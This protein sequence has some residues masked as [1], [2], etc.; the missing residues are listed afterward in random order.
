MTN[1]YKVSNNKLIIADKKLFQEYVNKNHGITPNI[2]NNIKKIPSN[3]FKGIKNIKY[4]FLPTNIKKIDI[5]VL[6]KMYGIVIN[7]GNYYEFTTRMLTPEGKKQVCLKVERVA[8]TKKFDNYL[9]YHD[10]IAPEIPEGVS[11]LGQF[12]F[13]NNKY[14]KSIVLPKSLTA[15]H[16]QSFMNSSL[17]TITISPKTIYFGEEAF[18]NCV[19]LDYMEI[20]KS[21]RYIKPNVFTKCKDSMKINIFNKYLILKSDFVL[22]GNLKDLYQLE[23]DNPNSKIKSIRTKYGFYI[24]E[25]DRTYF[26]NKNKYDFNQNIDKF[27]GYKYEDNDELFVSNI[28]YKAF[29]F[30]QKSKKI[31]DG[32]K[33]IPYTFIVKSTDIDNIEDYYKNEEFLKKNILNKICTISNNRTY[34]KNN[35]K[36]GRLTS[37]QYETIYKIAIIS[38]LFETNKSK[39]VNLFTQILFGIYRNG[40]NLS[41]EEFENLFSD[42]AN[43]CSVKYNEEFSEYFLYNKNN[44]IKIIKAA[45][46]KKNFLSDLYNNSGES[47]IYY[48]HDGK[49][50]KSHGKLHDMWIIYKNNNKRKKTLSFIDWA[51]LYGNESEVINNLNIEDKYKNILKKFNKYYSHEESYNKLYNLFRLSERV[52]PYA[53]Y[54]CH[55]S[56][57]LTVNV[58]PAEFQVVNRTFKINEKYIFDEENYKF[59]TVI[60]KNYCGEI[61][62]K[63]SYKVALFNCKL[64]S[65]AN[66]NST[67]AEYLYE[68]YLDPDCQP[69]VIF[70]KESNNPVATFRI[71]I[72]KNINIASIVSFEVSEIFKF[73]SNV[74]EKMNVVKIFEELVHNFVYLY[75][76]NNNIKIN[77]IVMGQVPHCGI[78]E[79]FNQKYEEI[80]V[81]YDLNYKRV[82]VNPS[83]KNNYLIWKR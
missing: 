14:L 10:G 46:N 33:I 26:F 2:P 25:N 44:L 41:I 72:Y 31:I 9:K 73:N 75:E 23:C 21:V 38:G 18:R 82:S 64:G 36:V 16:K 6:K 3:L 29:K 39:V 48:E 65:C 74:D 11:I 76:K 80:I 52:M 4:I 83:L 45:K 81:E 49:Y 54:S 55:H 79:I 78:N 20:P 56:S 59:H 13:K 66:I 28:G 34:D 60:Y 19:N 30:Y 12:V 63:D 47:N 42:I 58:S 50:I 70:E 68:S 40:L 57:L 24:M 43:D 77:M 1:Y 7:Y 62:N 15:I 35:K 32:K 71:N 61:I 53:Y 51:C 17:K 22:D 27:L 8:D 69:F 37:K 5:N 67:G